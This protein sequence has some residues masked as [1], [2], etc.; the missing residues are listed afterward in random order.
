MGRIPPPEERADYAPLEERLEDYA[1]CVVEERLEDFAR[2]V[3]DRDEDFLPGDAKEVLQVIATLAAA[4]SRAASAE[5]QLYWSDLN[6]NQVVRLWN[7]VSFHMWQFGLLH[8]AR[9]T[10]DAA[11]TSHR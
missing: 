8:L 4:E 5:P 7:A 1:D 9:C 6:Y 11:S 3:D 2:W 10:G